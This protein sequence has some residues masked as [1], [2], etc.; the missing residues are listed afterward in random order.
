VSF[1]YRIVAKRLGDKS[2]RWQDVT[3]R[4]AQME[5]VKADIAARNAAQPSAPQSSRAAEF[6]GPEAGPVSSS[7]VG[8]A[9]E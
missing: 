5:Q 1:D 7:A 9:V 4:M 3:A 6:G 2:V 8:R